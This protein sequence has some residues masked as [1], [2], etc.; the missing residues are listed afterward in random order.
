MN[1]QLYNWPDFFP[2]LSGLENSPVK[3]LN[4]EITKSKKYLTCILASVTQESILFSLQ[5]S[6]F[7]MPEKILTRNHKLCIHIRILKKKI[8]KR[9][10]QT[11]IHTK[12]QEGLSLHERQF[13]GF[14]AQNLAL[15][16]ICLHNESNT[17]TFIHKHISSFKK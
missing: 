12:F 10:L 3:T 14:G 2:T 5:M 13:A 16:Y 15:N 17:H 8:N 9:F 1:V 6:A 7:E 11:P 4:I